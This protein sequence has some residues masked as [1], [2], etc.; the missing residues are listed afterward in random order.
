[1]P[2]LKCVPIISTFYLK[3][4]KGLGFMECQGWTH[5]KEQKPH[6]DCSTWNFL[7]AHCARPVRQD[8]PGDGATLSFSVCFSMDAIQFDLM[9]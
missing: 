7:R 3:S 2:E 8:L 6:G 1:M 4:A 5:Q 9:T